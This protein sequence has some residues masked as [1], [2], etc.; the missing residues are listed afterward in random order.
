MK[1]EKVLVDAGKVKIVADAG[2]Y[3]FYGVCSEIMRAVYTKTEKIQKASLI[4][5]PEVYNKETKIAAMETKQEVQ[6]TAGRMKVIFSKENGL[7]TWYR[8]E[9]ELFRE[10]CKDLTETEVVRY[11][12]SGEKPVVKVKKTVDGERSFIENL[13]AVKE[14]TAYRGRLGFHWEKE[15]AIYG[16]G[17]GEEGI[18]NYRH[19]QQYLY[20]HNMRIPMP[21]L[22]SSKQYGVLVDCGSL[23][24]FNEETKPAYLFMDT[25]EQM[26][27]Y[28]MAGDTMDHVIKGYR[29]LTGKAAMLPKWAYGYVQSKEHYRTADEVLEIGK[30]YRERK[31]PLD[32]IVQDWNTWIPGKWGEKTLDSSRYANMKE[33]NARLHEMNI[34]TMVSIWPNMAEGGS[35]H[36][37]FV[38]ENKILGDYSTY[39][40]FDEEARALYWQQAKK[41]L[42]DVGFDSWWCD[43][44]EP[45]PGPDWGGEIMREPWERYMLVG[46]EHKKYLDAAQAN[47]F[48]MMHAKGIYEN[49]RQTC[50]NKRVLNLTRSGYASSQQYGVVLWSGDIAASWQTLKKQIAE[51]LNMCLSGMPYWTLDIGAFFVVGSA[52]QKRGCGNHNNPDKI[53]FWQGEY[54]DGVEDKGYKELYTRWFEYGTFLPMH[55]SHGTDTPREIWQFGEPGTIFYD[56]IEK[57]IHLR[58]QLMP[59]IYS[60]AGMVTQEDYTMMRG[61][62]FDFPEDEEVKNI[63]NQYM[64]GPSLLICPVTEPMYYEAENKEIYRQKVWTCY[65]PKGADWYHYWTN[66]YYQGGQYVTVLAPLGEMPVFVKAG[67]ILPMLQEDIQYAMQQPQKPILLR[68]YA[69]VDTT[70]TIYEDAG[71]NYAYEQGEFATTKITWNNQEEEVTVGGRIGEYGGMQTEN[72]YQIE[73]INGL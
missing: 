35:N 1:V 25:L 49:Q 73:I 37:E 63:G 60:L 64:F 41:G 19:H 71:D 68:V 23:M 62:I 24:T 17:Q 47:L 48:A 6:I 46:E 11:T 39:D 32:C 44:T 57:Y 26:D 13:K 20:Q 40:A 72:L 52:W 51:G 3:E 9:K 36:A 21:L 12:T 33:V 50:P 53:W 29:Y 27:Y 34:H 28:V 54:N 38:L 67:S 58:Y 66:K 22:V 56:T 59:Y 30:A 45:F 15:E 2:I 5:R 61:L 8:D 10:A 4:I 18:Y 42:F 55:R 43:S 14:R 65:L 16:L 69:G 70:F 31:V 7:C